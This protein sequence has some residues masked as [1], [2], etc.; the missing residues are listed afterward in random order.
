[1]AKI[2]MGSA[3]P[4]AP[5][6]RGEPARAGLPGDGAAPAGRLAAPRA[7]RLPQERPGGFPWQA[8]K[9]AGKGAGKRWRNQR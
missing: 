2:A 9:S 4:A 3:L 6:T 1:M 7:A 8:V 5:A